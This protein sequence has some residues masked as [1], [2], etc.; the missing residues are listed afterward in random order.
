MRWIDLVDKFWRRKRGRCGYTLR[1]YYRDV[2]DINEYGEVIYM[3]HGHAIA[4]WFVDENRLGVSDCGYV[5]QTTYSRL[6]AIVG[7]IGFTAF[8]TCGVGFL[9]DERRN[10]YYPMGKYMLS[11]D[12]DT[13]EVKHLCN[14]VEVKAFHLNEEMFSLV[15][16]LY[17]K[18]KKN[19][20]FSG[21]LDC[22]FDPEDLERRRM[23]TK[24]EVALYTIYRR[25]FSRWG[26]G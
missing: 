8:R 7:R 4:V 12:L 6:S 21:V 26:D 16:R 22:R 2:V 19:L 25:L 1:G 24:E 14:G 11:I 3:L 15:W 10:I 5:T 9:K 20:T 18:F 23:K 17:R 13:G